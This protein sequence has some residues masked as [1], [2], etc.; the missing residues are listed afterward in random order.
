M[1]SFL[2][3]KNYTPV[4]R[5]GLIKNNVYFQGEIPEGMHLACSPSDNIVIID[6]DKKNNKNGFL[7]IPEHL[8]GELNSTYWYKTKSGGAHVFVRYTGNKI[9]KN[10]STEKGI[11]LRIASNGKN[12]GGY[13]RWQ[14]DIRPEECINLIKESSTELNLFLEDL[15]S[16]N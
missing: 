4:V 12:C 5:W 3:N 10:M 1:K 6:I 2:L 7:Y 8:R 13:V 15:F 14:G 16:T 11:D 9:L